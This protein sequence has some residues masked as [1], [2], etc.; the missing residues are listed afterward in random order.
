MNYML[1]FLSVS[2]AS[3]SFLEDHQMCPNQDHPYLW[4]VYSVQNYF[5]RSQ[6]SDVSRHFVQIAQPTVLI[7]IIYVIKQYTL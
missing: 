1:M 4:M 3:G 7:K 6:V 5:Q 2:S